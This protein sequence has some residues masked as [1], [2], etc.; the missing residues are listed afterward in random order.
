MAGDKYTQHTSC[1]LMTNRDWNVAAL[2]PTTHTIKP[3]H[4]FFLYKTTQPFLGLSQ[5]SQT[6]NGRSDSGSSSS[7]DGVSTTSD[8]LVTGVT[9]PDTSSV[10]LDRLLTAERT[11]VTGVLLDLHLFGLTTQGGTVTNTELTSDTN[12]LSSLSPGKVLLVNLFEEQGEI[13]DARWVTA[14]ELQGFQSLPTPVLV[15]SILLNAALKRWLK[16]AK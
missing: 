10:S 4:E 9:V 6:S 3:D 5:L 8:G 1:Q 12:L 14:S 13:G 16:T 7:G 2:N 11:V 15:N